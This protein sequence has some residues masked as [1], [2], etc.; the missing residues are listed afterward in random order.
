MVPLVAGSSADLLAGSSVA[1]VDLELEASGLSSSE[2]FF[3]NHLDG[4]HI[5]G[6]ELVGEDG[7]GG[8]GGGKGSRGFGRV[9]FEVDFSSLVF[10]FYI[11]GASSSARELLRNLG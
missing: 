2:K 10:S 8:G 7:E 3:F 4:K 11:A 1:F 5:A 6:I 9:M